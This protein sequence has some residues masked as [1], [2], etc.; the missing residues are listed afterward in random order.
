LK[1]TNKQ[2]DAKPS[3]ITLQDLGKAMSQIDL[4]NVPPNKI[5]NAVFDQFMRVMQDTVQCGKTAYE[6]KQSRRLRNRL[7]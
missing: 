3:N 4:S 7:G 6:I 1:I 2:K 5:Q